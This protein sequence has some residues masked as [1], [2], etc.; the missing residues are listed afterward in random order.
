MSGRAGTSQE[1]P[2]AGQ[3]ELQTGG[4]GRLEARPPSPPPHLASRCPSVV[5][6]P[7]SGFSAAGGS[8]VRLLFGSP[9]GG[10]PSPVT[11]EVAPPCLSGPLSSAHPVQP[12]PLRSG[13]SLLPAEKPS[14]FFPTS[15]FFKAQRIA[16]LAGSLLGAS[17]GLTFS[18]HKMGGD[19][20]RDPRL[21]T[22]ST[23]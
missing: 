21:W 4:R 13:P 5:H 2:G 15:L 19:W 18:I 1:R 7:G 3:P 23:S 22:P 20:S 17:P 11:A 16:T 10:Q 12:L 14:C 9:G 8:Q 6:L